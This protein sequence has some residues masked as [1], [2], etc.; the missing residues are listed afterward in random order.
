MYSCVGKAEFSPLII[1]F[2]VSHNSLEIILI[3]EFGAQET[4]L[5]IINVG[6]G[7][8]LFCGNRDG[9]FFIGVSDKCDKK[10]KRAA[11]I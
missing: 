10:F 3:I 8:I 5:L 9:F 1:Q 6:N 11:F 4:F 2:A 7:F